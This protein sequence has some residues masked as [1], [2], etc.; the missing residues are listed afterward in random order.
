MQNYF[1]IFDLPLSFNIDKTKLKESFN[2]Q[3]I[4]F[5]PDKFIDESQKATAVKNTSLLNTAFN[6]LKSDLT[7]ASYILELNNISAFDE[8]DT[9]MNGAFL[10]EMIELQEELESLDSDSK[11]DKFIK[12]IDEKIQT[13]IKNL[14]LSF[15]D[16]NLEKSKNLVRELKFY[17]QTKNKANIK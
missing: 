15:D 6:T 9:Q 17:S 12:N 3:I 5:H 13:N 10:M 7:R 4:L 2:Q 1:D 11:I 14:A 16:N 8:K